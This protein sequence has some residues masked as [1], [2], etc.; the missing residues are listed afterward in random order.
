M[1]SLARGGDHE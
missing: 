1:D